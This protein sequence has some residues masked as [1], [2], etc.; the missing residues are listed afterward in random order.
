MNNN[1][2]QVYED[3]IWSL[4]EEIKT[5]TEEYECVQN[6]S[7]AYSEGELMK[8]MKFHDRTSQEHKQ[9]DSSPD[10][11]T[12]LD[13]LESD[14]SFIMKLTGIWFTNYSR[15]PIEK[16][17]NK[18]IH[19]Y[20]LS[21]NCQSVPFQLE[22]HI[23]EENQNNSNV[24]AIVTDL[25]IIIESEEHSDLSTLVSRVE[26][27]GNLLL[28]FKSLSCFSEWYE[29]RKCTWT[30][31]KRKYPDVVVLPEGLS[32]DYMILRNTKLPGFELMIVWKICV[33]KEGKV[34]P[35]LDL[36]SKIPMADLEAKNF[37]SDAPNCFRSLL[38]VLGIQ[39]SIETLIK[40]LCM[41]K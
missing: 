6:A 15:K 40:S 19:K 34:M 14:L 27:N 29:H 11:K 9:R 20:R 5:L 3:E 36:L 24:S 13:L 30:H 26:E 33:D 37:A 2:V 22:F 35:I 1:I 25:N 7:M 32:G 10:L 23:M 12:Q 21:G 28:F 8:A 4:E 39:D 16:S 18:T 41:G 31:F 17:G 38:Q